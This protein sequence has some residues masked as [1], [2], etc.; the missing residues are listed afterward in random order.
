MYVHTVANTEFRNRMEILVLTLHEALTIHTLGKLVIR[1][2]IR[3]YTPIVHTYTCT[4]GTYYTHLCHG[5]YVG[6]SNKKVVHKTS[7][8]YVQ[9]SH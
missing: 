1:V 2:Y 6:R 8:A 5:R 9:S 7:T 4:C 3:M